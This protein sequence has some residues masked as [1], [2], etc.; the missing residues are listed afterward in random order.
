[1]QASAY[2]AIEQVSM[3]A[4]M[5]RSWGLGPEAAYQAFQL[6]WLR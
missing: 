3:L 5:D 6:P 2:L 4:V 1:M